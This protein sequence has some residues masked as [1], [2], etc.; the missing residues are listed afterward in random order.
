MAAP[1]SRLD[2]R[3]NPHLKTEK[4]IIESVLS[5]EQREGL[6]LPSPLFSKRKNF[7]EIYDS[8]RSFSGI[9]QLFDP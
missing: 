9:R 2:F 6:P 5:Q 7:P 8:E 1:F 3:Q 4:N